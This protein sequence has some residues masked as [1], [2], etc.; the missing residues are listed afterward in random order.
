MV[1][2]HWRSARASRRG[3]TLI[4]L[5]VVIAII[6][7]L[8]GLLLPAVQ[9]VREA[10]ARMSCSNNLKQMGLA[11]HNFEGAYKYLPAAVT[12]PANGNQ[13]IGFFVMILPFVEQSALF[14]QYDPTVK[15]NNQINQGV[16]N[17]QIK[18][19]SCP[20]ANPLIWTFGLAAPTPANPNANASM[21]V[22]DYFP[23]MDTN[24]PSPQWAEGMLT[25]WNNAHTVATGFK[26]TM[27]DVTDGLSNSVMVGE[28]ASKSQLWQMRTMTAEPSTGNAQHAGWGSLSGA[29]PIKVFNSS[30]AGLAA[31][32]E[33][34]ATCTVNCSNLAGVYSF[35]SGGANFLFGDGSVRFL[36]DSLPYLTLR[37][38]ISRAEGEVITSGDY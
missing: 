6:A 20:S 21:V 2:A 9:K 35:H 16:I 30:G 13:Q 5:L 27:N 18:I 28:Q 26:P 32:L 37:A 3:F 11:V 23:M 34:T 15:W 29:Q 36:R 31:G 19:Y 25:I 1:R 17:A 10:A 4:E 8:I 38:L 22:G 24:Y 33:N 12:Q 14:A 7:I